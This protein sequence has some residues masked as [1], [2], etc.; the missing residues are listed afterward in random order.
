MIL[1]VFLIALIFIILLVALPF[2]FKL[3]FK[4]KNFMGFSIGVICSILTFATLFIIITVGIAF[5]NLILKRNYIGGIIFI[6]IIVISV[7]IDIFLF[8]FFFS[9][10]ISN[11][12]QPYNCVFMFIAGYLL[13]LFLLIYLYFIIIALYSNDKRKIYIWPFDNYSEFENLIILEFFF[14][15]YM[16][17]LAGII[18]LSMLHHRKVNKNIIIILLVCYFL[19]FLLNLIGNFIIGIQFLIAIAMLVS[20]IAPLI[21]GVYFYRKYANQGMPSSE[22]IEPINSM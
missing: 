13:S 17:H 11:E 22:I 4:T 2:I 10:R 15:L 18:M 3:I 7:Y 8:I 6:Y 19:P 9:K 5:A 12:N 1:S 20:F 14:L 16:F 21:F